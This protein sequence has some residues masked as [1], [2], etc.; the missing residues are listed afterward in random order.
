MTARAPQVDVRQGSTISRLLSLTGFLQQHQ[1]VG[2]L[3]RKRAEQN[4]VHHGKHGC[5]GA[6]AQRQGK[7]CYCSEARRPAQYAKRVEHVLHKRPDESLNSTKTTMVRVERNLETHSKE[8][9]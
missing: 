6:Q 5:A 8:A 1:P 9:P 2:I 3:I 4:T 7:D